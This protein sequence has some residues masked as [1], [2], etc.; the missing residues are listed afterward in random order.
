MSSKLKATFDPI[1]Y[2]MLMIMLKNKFLIIARA[3]SHKIS[4]VLNN[5]PQTLMSIHSHLTAFLDML[6][7]IVYIM[8]LR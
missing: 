6:R 3:M 1:P 7:K 8:A 4:G 5:L 2:N